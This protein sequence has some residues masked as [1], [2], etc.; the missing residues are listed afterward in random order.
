MEHTIEVHTTFLADLLFAMPAVVQ[1]INDEAH[2]ASGKEN[3]E[4]IESML[5]WALSSSRYVADK[6]TH[7]GVIEMLLERGDYPRDQ[8]LN[9]ITVLKSELGVWCESDEEYEDCKAAAKE[10]TGKESGHHMIGLDVEELKKEFMKCESKEEAAKLFAKKMIDKIDMPEDVDKESMT[11]DLARLLLGKANKTGGKDSKVFGTVTARR[12]Y[13]YDKKKTIEDNI[14]NCF[15]FAGSEA[16][17]LVA[18]GESL[19]SAEAKVIAPLIKELVK[20]ITKE[21]L[22]QQKESQH[23]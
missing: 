1:A 11:E 16:G 3:H 9:A 22:N 12:R 15:R 18:Q 17:E 5:D 4:A 21:I 19:L 8:V 2:R 6:L 13:K 10:I 23:D 20:D 14:F 7:K